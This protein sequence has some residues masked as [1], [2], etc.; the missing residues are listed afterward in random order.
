MGRSQTRTRSRRVLRQEAGKGLVVTEGMVTEPE[1]LDGFRQF[2][3]S[4][5]AVDIVPIQ[6]TG[7]GKDP[8]AVLEKA[9]ELREK[10]DYDWVA[11]LVDVDEHANLNLAIRRARQEGVLLVVSNLKFE[12]WLLWHTTDSRRSMNSQ[13]LDRE[14]RKENLVVGKKGKNISPNFPYAEHSRASRNA[15]QADPELD[16]YRKGPCPSTAMPLLIKKLLGE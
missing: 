12:V 6:V 11:C 3:R 5:P 2:Y 10:K 15:Y 1:Y 4:S 7:V 9:L 8:L 14:V 13:E 16:F